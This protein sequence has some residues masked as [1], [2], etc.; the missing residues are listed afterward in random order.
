MRFVPV[1]LSFTYRTIE[2]ADFRDSFSFSPAASAVAFLQAVNFADRVS[3]RYGFDVRYRAEKFKPHACATKDASQWLALRVI[4]L[5][6]A[7]TD[8]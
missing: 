3:L 7:T 2:E 4:Q 8:N 1:E 6:S 5:I